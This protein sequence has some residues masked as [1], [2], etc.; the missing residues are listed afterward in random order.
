[1]TKNEGMTKN[2]MRNS[3]LPLLLGPSAIRTSFVIRH[4]CFAITRVS[5][6]LNGRQG[7]STPLRHDQIAFLVAPA[8]SESDPER[9]RIALL[10]EL[11]QFWLIMLFEELDRAQIR[12]EEPQVPLL[13]IKI[14]QWNPGIILHNQVAVVENEI[15]D[16]GEIIFEHQIR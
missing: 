12:A 4:S 11:L 15:A 7:H 2:G 13:A 9:W 10:E 8:V 16:G 3:N 1:M 14:G 5:C 6:A